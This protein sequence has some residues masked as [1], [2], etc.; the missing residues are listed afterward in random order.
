[1]D[2]EPVWKIWGSENSWSYLDSNSDLSIVRPAASRY[3][4]C[5]NA[6]FYVHKQYLWTIKI[7]DIIH[8]PLIYLK[9]NI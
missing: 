6:E 1:M 7:L 2:P 8:H 4:G 5:I 3:T 9:H